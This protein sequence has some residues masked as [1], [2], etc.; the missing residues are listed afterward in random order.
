VEPLV[1]VVIPVHNH[2]TWIVEST[3]SA[4]EQSYA[5]VEVVCVDDGSTDGSGEVVRGLDRV[6]VYRVPNGG[7]SA[8]R[9]YGLA[10]ARGE[11]VQ[12][13]DADDVLHRDKLARQVPLLRDAGADVV[14]SPRGRVVGGGREILP[15]TV[16]APPLEDGDPFIYCCRYSVPGQLHGAITV[17]TPLF[18]RSALERVQGFREHVRWGEEKE[19]MLR[20]TC[21]NAEVRSV[22]DLLYGY[23]E[24]AGEHVSTTRRPPGHNLRVLLRLADELSS[25]AVY[26]FT[27]ARRRVFGGKVFEAAVGAYRNG[28]RDLARAAFRRARELSPGLDFEAGPAYRLVVRAFG[29]VFAERLVAARRRLSGR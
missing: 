24:H 16:P 2:A 21:A 13:L 28:E 27:P 18:R 8:A 9:N 23:R 4:L 10:R 25:S 12:F 5:P 26:T 19:L 29:P 7:P 11:Y 22:A 6:S 3:R 1:S 20:V 17:G 15:A 14:L